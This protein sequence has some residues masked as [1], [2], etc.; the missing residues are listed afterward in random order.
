MMGVVGAA[1]ALALLNVAN[2]T[3]GAQSQA[4]SSY[5]SPARRQPQP[6]RQLLRRLP[7]HLP[8]SDAVQKDAHAPTREA[9]A[10]IRT[11]MEM[12]AATMANA[13]EPNP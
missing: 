13:P 8:A 6:A 1:A 4:D 2:S 3:V 10:S 12:D 5:N 11:Q 9:A 7:A